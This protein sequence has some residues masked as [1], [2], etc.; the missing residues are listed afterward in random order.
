MHVEGREV[1]ARTRGSRNE[2]ED[3]PLAIPLVACATMLVREL[4]AV[5]PPNDAESAIVRTLSPGSYTAIVR[6]VNQTSGIALIE[7]YALR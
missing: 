6:G 4:T 7:V 2:T 5:P 1:I 3:F